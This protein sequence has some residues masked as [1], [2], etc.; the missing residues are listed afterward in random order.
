M[1]AILARKNVSFPP[2]ALLALAA[3]PITL[4][5][6]PKAPIA[7]AVAAWAASSRMTNPDWPVPVAV[8][9]MLH[10]PFVGFPLG[11]L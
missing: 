2:A 5:A 4:F 10:G 8:L 11:L 3:K 6:L 1:P 9:A 7:V